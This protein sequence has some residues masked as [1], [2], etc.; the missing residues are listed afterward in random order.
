MP[1]SQI[2]LY[3]S[4]VY[5]WTYG[6][7][8]GRTVLMLHGFRGNHLGLLKIIDGLGEYRVIVP[9]LPGFGISTPMTELPHTAAGYSAFARALITGLQ[10]DRPVVLGHSYGSVI[11][12]HLAASEPESVSEL[13]LVSPIAASPRA[14]LNRP[15][16]TLVA[17]Y[18]WLGT[19][20]PELLGGKVLMSKTFNRLM[21]LTLMKTRDPATRRAIYRH[22]LGDLQFVEDRRV[23][24]E[25]FPDSIT[26]TAGDAAEDIPQ[27]TLL[28]AGEKDALSPARYQ[29][30]LV[31]R[32]PRGSLVL[33]PH[34]GHLVHLE[35]P[36][37]AAQA[38][39]RFLTR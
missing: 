25:S 18:Y 34:V 19:H 36:R 15:V 12:S 5:Y 23:I 1:S 3:G 6:P 28:I 32:L 11:A 8:G 14:G 16:S 29:R 7:A 4:Q 17:W 9:D 30:H 22:H 27:R 38:I 20:L 2:D 39:R 37:E 24:A 35:T 33:I 10:L 26:K 13:V 31:D 21:S